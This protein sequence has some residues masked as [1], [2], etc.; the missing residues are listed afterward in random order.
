MKPTDNLLNSSNCFF[1][2]GNCVFARNCTFHILLASRIATYTLRTQM[3]PS[4]KCH[5]LC[6]RLDGATTKSKKETIFHHLQRILKVEK[7]EENRV[8]TIA[9]SVNI[10]YTK[11]NIDKPFLQKSRGLEIPRTG[12]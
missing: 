2:V 3:E 12:R 11:M 4:A 8:K 9:D 1:S 5:Y 10:Y 6:K 7:Y